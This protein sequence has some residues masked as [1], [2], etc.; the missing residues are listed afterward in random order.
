MKLNRSAA[1]I[2]ATLLVAVTPLF[3]YADAVPKSK[4]TA[5][6]AAILAQVGSIMGDSYDGSNHGG[7][8]SAANEN[9]DQLLKNL[10]LDGKKFSRGQL[11]S[12]I[13]RSNADN[14]N[15]VA[16]ADADADENSD[17][18]GAGQGK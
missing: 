6:D 15:A 7:I 16:D 4:V 13:A 12:I 9:F 3:A 10:S 5:S 1:I 8:V 17:E 11:I 2:V 18:Q 14:G